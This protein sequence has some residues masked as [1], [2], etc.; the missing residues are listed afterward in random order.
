MKPYERYGEVLMLFTSVQGYR[1][2]PL[3]EI[4]SAPGSQGQLR[5]LSAY[6]NSFKW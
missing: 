2:Y 5:G 3:D 1:R 6:I 4:L